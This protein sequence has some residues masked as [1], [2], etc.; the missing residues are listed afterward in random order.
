MAEATGWGKTLIL[1][2]CLGVA[3]CVST[4]P[5]DVA[6]GVGFQDYR[7][8]LARQAR[9]RGTAPDTAARYDTVTSPLGVD[10]ATA[11]A[12][13]A[14][15]TDDVIA[16]RAAAA[17]AQADAPEAAA[18]TPAATAALPRPA[19]RAPGISD[20]QEFAAV[21]ARETIESDAERRASMQAQRVDIAAQALPERPTDLGPSIAAYALATQNS[22]GEQ[23]YTRTPFGQGQ[24]AAN[25]QA[26]RASDLAQEWFLANGGPERDR[27]ALDP[28]GDGFVC[29]LD[30]EAFRA[31]ARAAQQ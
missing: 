7:E 26:F 5:N 19:G 24:H 8:F 2:A 11:A 10:P 14:A 30:P 17:I 27:R 9:L 25:C 6:Q 31:A 18:T 29:A 22:V 21:A 15:T 1:M 20:E 23:R 12:P 16:A 13:A 3:G 4:P 28:D